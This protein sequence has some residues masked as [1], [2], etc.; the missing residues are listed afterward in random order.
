MILLPGLSLL[1]NLYL[2]NVNSTCVSPFPPP[3]QVGQDGQ[4]GLG[5]GMVLIDNTIIDLTNSLFA[6][7]L[8]LVFL[9]LKKNTIMNILRA[10]SICISFIFL[11]QNPRSIVVRSVG[12]QALM[13]NRNCLNACHKFIFPP[14]MIK[15][16]FS[17]CRP[18]L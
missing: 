5:L 15:C 18:A 3:P 12:M 8:S 13:F 14:K 4:S 6:V 17:V 2:Q 16:L 11:V 9:Q 1:R 7:Y 10:K